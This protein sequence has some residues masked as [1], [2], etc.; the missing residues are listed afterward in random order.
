MEFDKI[1]FV[2]AFPFLASIFPGG[3]LFYL[4]EVAHRGT[5]SRFLSIS[6]FGYKSKLLLL[7]LMLFLLG[8]SFNKFVAAL[9]ESAGWVLGRICKLPVFDRHPY[10]LTTA[11]WRDRR[12]RAAYARRFAIDVPRDI[13]LTPDSLD[14]EMLSA[15]STLQPGEQPS[16]EQSAYAMRVLHAAIDRISN[17]QEWK[18][19]YLQLHV[20]EITRVE[21]GFVGEIGAGL[22]S[23][24]TIASV[25]LVV[26]SWF[27]PQ[28]R[29]WWLLFPAYLWFAKSLLD[30]AQKTVRFINPSSTL[31]AQFDS[32]NALTR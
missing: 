24:L 8:Y 13:A 17:D 14:E 7:L 12:W 25:I 27:V 19:R 20:A 18:L 6:I 21:M 32:L 16:A 2:K 28:I 1:P 30:V 4:F 26:A 23:N 22:D 15:I 5:L 31:Q 9:S 29:F 11:P 3:A 10:D